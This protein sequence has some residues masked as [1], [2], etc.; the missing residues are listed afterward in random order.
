MSKKI[1]KKEIF[2]YGKIMNKLI[3]TDNELLKCI[4]ATDL[5][6]TYFEGRN[7]TNFRLIISQLR[8]DLEK[9]LGYKDARNLK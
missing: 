5:V 6:L 4:E 9:L 8:R 3:L 1:T 2:K 7:D